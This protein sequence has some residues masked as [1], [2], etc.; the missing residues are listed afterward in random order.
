MF[1]DSTGSVTKIDGTQKYG[2]LAHIALILDFGHFVG[3]YGRHVE[4]R[5]V[6]YASWYMPRVAQRLIF[7]L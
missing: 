3:S 1:L 6:I 4:A 5:L 2:S 7:T